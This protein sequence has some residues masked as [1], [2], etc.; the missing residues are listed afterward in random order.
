MGPDYEYTYSMVLML[1]QYVIPSGVLIFTYT[2]IGVAI[3]CHRIPGEAEN[4]RDQRIAK[5]KKKVSQFFRTLMILLRKWQSLMDLLT[6]AIS[7]VLKVYD[8]TK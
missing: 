8:M 4:S 5:S 7:G 3:W 2:R 1:L 6:E